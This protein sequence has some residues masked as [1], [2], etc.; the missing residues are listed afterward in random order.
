MA[1]KKLNTI[2]K[3]AIYDAERYFTHSTLSLYVR[4]QLQIRGKYR[5]KIFDIETKKF[6]FNNVNI[7]LWSQN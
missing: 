6:S 2:T 7:K 1:Y 4:I 3:V 5:S